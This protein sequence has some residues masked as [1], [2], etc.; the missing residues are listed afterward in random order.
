MCNYL[1]LIRRFSFHFSLYDGSRAQAPQI[2]KTA[3]GVVHTGAVVQGS[4]VSSA[5]CSEDCS[6]R[7]GSP[8]C[9]GPGGTAEH[10]P[11]PGLTG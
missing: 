8:G 4:L 1:S 3:L 11:A 2:Q 6:D 10:I 7:T 5:Y 9:S